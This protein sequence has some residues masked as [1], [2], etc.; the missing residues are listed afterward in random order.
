M[1]RLC[2]S[3]TQTGLTAFTSAIL[4]VLQAGIVRADQ[5]APGAAVSN[6]GAADTSGTLEEVV[7]T[8][9]KREENAQSVPDS[10]LVLDPATIESMRVTQ[11]GDVGKLFPN[12]SFRQDLSVT[13]TF[14]SIRGITATRNTDPAV[15]LIIDGV[16]TSNASAIRE[17]LDDVDRIEVLKG[18]QG[19]LYGRDAIAGA[20]NVVTN[21]PTNDMEGHATVG[22]GNVGEVEGQGVFSGAIVP[23]VL[24]F[25]ASA[26]Y[27]NDDGD[28][29]DPAAGDQNVNFKSDKV[30]MLRLIYKPVEGL[31]FDFKYNHD[32]YRGGAYYF[33]VTR[34]IGAPFPYSNPSSNSNTFSFSPMSVPISVNYS[35]INDSSLRITD[36]LSFAT[37]SSVTAYSATN[38]WY[39]VAGQGIG[40]DQPGDLDF[41]PANIEATPQTF[42]I[43]STSEEVR[44]TSNGAGPLRWM[45][46]LYYLNLSRDDTLPFYILNGSTNPADWVE[47]Y[48]LGTHRTIKAYAGFAQLDYDL[49]NK[50]TATLGFRY[51]YEDRTQFNYDSPSLGT[52]YAT[53]DL[54]QPKLSLAYK[55]EPDQMAYVTVSRGFRSG[56]FNVPRSIFAPVYQPEELWNY[57]VG[58]KAD[59]LD[60]TFRTDAA[61]FYEDI[62]NVQDFVFDGVN[63]A[64]TIYNIPKAHVEGVE[65]NLAYEPIRKLVF[66]GNV[67][68]M[69]SKIQQF[70]YGPLFP[71]PLVNANIDGNH[72]PGFSHWGVQVAADYSRPLTDK[73]EASAHMDYSVRGKQYWDITNIDVEK[74]VSLLGA[75]FGI[76][77]GAYRLSLWGSNLLNTQYWSNWFNQQTTGLPDVGYPAEPRRFGVRLTAHF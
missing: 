4:C 34:P 7:V 1:N 35:Y 11:A 9:R 24:L 38:E 29:K 26:Y 27:H 8:A 20:I 5:T 52:R 51:D 50:F 59:W 56:G 33:D 25:R 67:G 70:I 60:K 54:P 12:V 46:G 63:A 47:Y 58:Y 72:L 19:S 44:L 65:L 13:S 76:S 14:I 45:A 69:D 75:E 77:K 37:L 55:L 42:L 43:H 48:P 62:T 28:I 57:E 41:T 68:L 23:D 10:L 15:S 32:E 71:T 53:F 21:M 39:G 2:R 61:L 73:V 40:G 66:S 16:Q 74:D 36:D 22:F 49:T 3:L 64:Q 30:G 6:A 18:P 17:Q 31:M